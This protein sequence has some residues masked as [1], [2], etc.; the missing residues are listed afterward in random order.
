MGTRPR[1]PHLISDK[2]K[3]LNFN[4]FLIKST[5]KT[6]L[7]DLFYEKKLKAKIFTLVKNITKYILGEI[8]IIELCEVV[9][10]DINLKFMNFNYNVIVNIKVKDKILN[11]CLIYL[12]IDYTK[13]K[14][15]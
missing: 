5:K 10:R 3:I 14:E 4:H 9:F 1:K 11:S 8:F 15:F 6:I 7:L 13:Y 2:S 12:N